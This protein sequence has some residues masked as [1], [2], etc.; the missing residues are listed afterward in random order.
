MPSQ[1]THFFVISFCF[2]EY[3]LP[4]SPTHSPSYRFLD[5]DGEEC[6]ECDRDDE[7]DFRLSLR[8]LTKIR[9]TESPSTIWVL[10][11]SSPF[12]NPPCPNQ[13]T[14]RNYTSVR[15]YFALLVAV[16][17]ITVGVSRVRSR[18][19]TAFF[20]LFAS[21]HSTKSEN[22]FQFKLVDSNSNE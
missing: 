13:N 20:V 10:L 1:T 16:R 15:Q 9:S 8:T 22:P 14:N 21:T 5:L 17:V 2:G 18:I 12:W 7:Y 6:R 11:P 19:V 3:E 4:I